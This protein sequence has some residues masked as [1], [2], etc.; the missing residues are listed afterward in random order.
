MEDENGNVIS[1]RMDIWIS[2]NILDIEFR[3]VELEIGKS[4]KLTLKTYDSTGNFVTIKK[5]FV[6]NNIM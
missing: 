2:G 5:E 4:Y 6:V 3:N 1:N